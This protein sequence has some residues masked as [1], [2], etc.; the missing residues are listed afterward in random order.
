MTKEQERGELHSTI[1]KIATC[2]KFRQVVNV[3]N[4]RKATLQFDAFKNN[5]KEVDFDNL[6][7]IE[8]EGFRTEKK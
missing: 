6:K 1:W 2:Q 8:F 5:T 3:L 7:P 4:F